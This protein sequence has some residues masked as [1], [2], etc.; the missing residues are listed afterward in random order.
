MPNFMV[1]SA[2][3]SY[4][5][6]DLRF[7]NWKSWIFTN[8]GKIGRPL[9]GIGVVWHEI[10]DLSRFCGKFT[11]LLSPFYRIWIFC[12]IGPKLTRT[13][14][15]VYSHFGPIF[16]KIDEKRQIS[17]LSWL[18][19]SSNLVNLLKICWKQLVNQSCFIFT[20]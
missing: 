1:W 14:R 12:L 16:S 19:M 18:R 4:I 8:T 17:R 6:V 20:S 2:L 9:Q 15:V 11:L 13:Y 5:F 3:D 7:F 10:F